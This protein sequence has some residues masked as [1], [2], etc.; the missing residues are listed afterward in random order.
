[1]L[2]QERH[3]Q[4]VPLQLPPS[5]FSKKKCLNGILSNT[6]H[7]N[8][9]IAKSQT[10]FRS[11]AMRCNTFCMKDVGHQALRSA[12]SLSQ[13]VNAVLLLFAVRFQFLPSVW[14]VFVIVLYE[15]LLGGAAYVNTFYFI[16]LET[17]DRHREFAMAAASVGDSLGIALAGLTAFPV[18][19]YFCSL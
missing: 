7:V 8:R 2:T 9:K 1:M 18:H 4:K 13:V 5:C 6:A 12:P 10:H 17:G 11:L 16:S 14:L 19:R 15:G 3:Q